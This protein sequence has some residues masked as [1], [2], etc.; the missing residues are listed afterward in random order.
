MS[1]ADISKAIL[2]DFDS[3]KGGSVFDTTQADSLDNEISE[4]NVFGKGHNFR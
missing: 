3:M 1:A 4:R 2:A